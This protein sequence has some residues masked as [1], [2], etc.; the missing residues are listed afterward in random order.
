MSSGQCHA[1]GPNPLRRGGVGHPPNASAKAV[2]IPRVAW[3][4][5]EGDCVAD[6]REAGDVGEGAF[7]AEAE[8][9]VLATV[10]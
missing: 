5:R 10:P 6:V 8:A 7:E 1:N 2:S 9:G 4:S 3:R